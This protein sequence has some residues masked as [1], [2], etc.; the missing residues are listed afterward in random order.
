MC[1]SYYSVQDSQGAHIVVIPDDY[2]HGYKSYCSRQ[3][4]NDIHNRRNLSHER[5]RPCL[6]TVETA[7]KQFQPFFDIM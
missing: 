3:K 1:N 5:Q 2:Y 7:S 4:R 6:K